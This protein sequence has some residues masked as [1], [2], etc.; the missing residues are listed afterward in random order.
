MTNT[1]ILTLCPS[2]C[3]DPDPVKPDAAVHEGHG[4]YSAEPGGYLPMLLSISVDGTTSSFEHGAPLIA[5]C[6]YRREV[7]DH[8]DGV[9]LHIAGR[10]GDVEETMLPFHARQLAHQLLVAADLVDGEHR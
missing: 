6:A 9:L 4:H 1:T 7:G 5:A 3:D 2:F 8:P 10:S